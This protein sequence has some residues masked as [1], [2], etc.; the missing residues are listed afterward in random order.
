MNRNHRLELAKRLERARL[1]IKEPKKAEETTPS[2]VW[3][4]HY[5]QYYVDDRETYETLPECLKSV[6]K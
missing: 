6:K 2:Y 3:P 1:N 5:Y 4:D